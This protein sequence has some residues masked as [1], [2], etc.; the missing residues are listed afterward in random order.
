M[1]TILSH[2]FNVF[3]MEIHGVEILGRDHRTLVAGQEHGAGEGRGRDA[4]ETAGGGP[5]LG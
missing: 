1:I 5:G 2:E 3:I 4:L